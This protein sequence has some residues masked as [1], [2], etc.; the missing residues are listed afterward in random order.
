MM[1]FP[2]IEIPINWASYRGGATTTTEYNIHFFYK[3]I[4]PRTMCTWYPWGTQQRFATCNDTSLTATQKRQSLTL[5]KFCSL[6]RISSE[7]QTAVICICCFQCRPV[8]KH[9]KEMSLS[10]APVHLGNRRRQCAR[11]SHYFQPTKINKGK[12]KKPS[13]GQQYPSKIH[14]SGLF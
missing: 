7:W 11:L 3:L 8:E 2:P 6:C 1:Y 9:G 12:Q 14:L 10:A 5:C 4:V 13:I